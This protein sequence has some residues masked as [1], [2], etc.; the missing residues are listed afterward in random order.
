LRKEGIISLGEAF[1]DL[2]SKDKT[3]TTYQQFLG[4]ATVNVIVGTSRYGIPSFYICKLGTDENSIFVENE[5]IKEKIN[6]DYCVRSSEKKV[7]SVYVHLDDNGDRYFHTYVNETPDEWLTE[8]ELERDLFL[9]GKIFYFSS[10]TLFHNIARRTTEQALT[11]ARESQTL[12][13]FDANIRLKRWNSEEECREMISSFLNRADIVKMTEDELL[14]LTET[15]TI[16][17]GLDKTSEMNIPFLFITMGKEGACVVHSG[18]RM[19]VPGIRVNVVDTT[20]AGDAF[21]AAILYCF[22]KKGIPLDDVQLMEYVQF[23]NKAGALTTTKIGS[24]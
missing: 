19:T 7:C 1:V 5:L 2:I 21:L 4:G 14:F 16:D 6:I 15:K 18:K 24:L 22:H 20:G 13:A 8:D 9:K 23:A 10:G 3:N 11:Y 12:V 17:E